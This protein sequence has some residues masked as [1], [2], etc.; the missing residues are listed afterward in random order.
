MFAAFWFPPGMATTCLPGPSSLTSFA[1]DGPACADVVG[2]VEAES[3][4]LGRVG[5]E[6]H[7][8]DALLDGRVDGRGGRIGHGATNADAVH[9]LRHQ[10]LDVLDLLLGVLFVG[11]SPE[12][13][14]PHAQLV[15]RDR[16]RRLPPPRGP[17]G[18]P[19]STG[20]WRPWRRR[21]PSL[22][23]WR[24]AAVWLPAG[25]SAVFWQPVRPPTKTAATST[26]EPQGCIR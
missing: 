20:S 17:P 25:V 2:A 19:D 22:P 16:G 21:P 24:E 14:D 10:L 18:R 15:A 13:F 12:D 4:A 9:A 3:L 11:R 26:A 7:H 23:V 1:H 8:R 5:I 6:A